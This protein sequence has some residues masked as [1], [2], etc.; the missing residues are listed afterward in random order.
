MPDVKADVQ[1]GKSH[2]RCGDPRRPAKETGIDCCQ[3]DG[4]EELPCRHM[5]PFG[6]RLADECE[7]DHDEPARL[8]DTE[9][10]VHRCGGKPQGSRFGQGPAKEVYGE[11]GDTDF[12]DEE[13][14]AL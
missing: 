6:Q 13:P 4:T 7:R 3:Q 1:L 5:D 14:E 10:I 11:E 9:D 12:D 2:D 8:E